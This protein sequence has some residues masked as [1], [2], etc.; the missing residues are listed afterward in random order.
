MPLSDKESYVLNWIS[1]VS[2]T[3]EDLKGFAICPF[4]SQAKYKIIECSAKEIEPIEGYQVI[5]FIVEDDF[6]IDNVRHWVDHYN[7]LYTDWSFFEDC[8]S[9]DTYINGVQTNNGKY[10][11]ILAQPT[12]KLRKFR[13]KLA[14]TSYYNLWDEEYLREIMGNDYD[15]VEKRDSNP[16]KS[17][18]F[19]NQEQK[20]TK[21]VD[22]NEDYMKSTWGTEYL[23]SEYGWESK[24]EEKKMLREINNDDYTPKK[25]DFAI[26]NE[27]HEKIR[28]DEDYDDWEYGT[29]PFYKMNK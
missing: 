18:D 21:K 3:R 2:Q 23:S 11:L 17:S 29:E 1:Y 27:I 13:E 15:I 9:Y 28:N 10:N 4:S 25:H 8:K 16:V 20:M 26:Q 7:N 5:I 14:K 22:K 6:K 19:Q 24:I 12:E